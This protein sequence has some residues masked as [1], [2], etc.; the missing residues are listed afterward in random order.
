MSN[1]AISFNTQGILT[2][3]VILILR[4]KADLGTIIYQQAFTANSQHNVTV[5]DLNPVMHQAEIWDTPDGTTLGALRGQCDIDAAQNSG[6]GSFGYIQFKVDSGVVTGTGITTA[7]TCPVDG[8]SQYVDTALDGLN[9]LVAKGGIIMQ[10]GSEIQMIAGGGFEYID[11]QK[12]SSF[13]EYTIIVANS[14]AGAPTTTSSK[15]LTDVIIHTADATLDNT[16]RNKLNVFNFAGNVAVLTMETLASVT[17]K[18]VWVFSTHRG[19]QINGEIAFQSGEG[20]YFMGSLR[21]KIQL[22]KNETIKMVVKTGVCYCVDY[23]GCYGQVGDHIMTDINGGDNRLVMDGLTAYD[24]NTYKRLYDWATT[25]LAAGQKVTQALYDTQVSV[26]GVGTYPNRGKYVVDT[27][28]K[29]VRLPDIRGNYQRAIDAAGSAGTRMDWQVG[30]HHHEAGTEPNPI[31]KFQKGTSH[32]VRA[33]SA[34]AGTT[35]ELAST[36]LN[37]HSDGTIAASGDKNEV[38]SIMYYPCIII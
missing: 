9:Y 38:N 5:T 21:N 27:T 15:E 30:A 29:T 28:A 26:N 12:F 23:D 32:S 8:D 22:G 24:G 10:W 6:S 17:D 36:D 37:T 3:N 4:E 34:T 1:I 2:A 33:W 31:G 11:G 7:G 20:C 16:H 19:S 18:T 13:D 14:N 35:S 25:V